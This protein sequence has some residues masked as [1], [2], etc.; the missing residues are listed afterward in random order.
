MTINK[1]TEH[2]WTWI[3]NIWKPTENQLGTSGHHWKSKQAHSG[4]KQTHSRVKNDIRGPCSQNYKSRK[5]AGPKI[6]RVYWK[7]RKIQW[8]WSQSQL[9]WVKITRLRDNSKKT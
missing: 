3:E 6:L 4:S 5:Y 7:D 1:I 8:S 2:L 9:S